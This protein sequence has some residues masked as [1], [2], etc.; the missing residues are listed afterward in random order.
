MDKTLRNVLIIGIL[1]LSISSIF[2]FVYL[3]YK[4]SYNF[5]ECL[6]FSE[7]TFNQKTKEITDH[8]NDLEKQKD[9]AQKEAD[10]MFSEFIKSNPEPK[11]EDYPVSNEDRN[12]VDKTFADYYR[13]KLKLNISEEYSIEHSKWEMQKDE[14]FREI[15][16]IMSLSKLIKSDFE[17]IEKERKSSEDICYK[18]FK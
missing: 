1:A 11:K 7:K 12:K 13:L 14:I 15:N 5:N 6:G 8:I 2:Y 17:K 18:K 10:E 16:R 9:I 3:P 4:K